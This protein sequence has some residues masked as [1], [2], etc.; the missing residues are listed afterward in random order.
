MVGSDGVTGDCAPR[1]KASDAT[2]AAMRAVAVCALDG[3]A[4]ACAHRSALPSR[5]DR[6][7]HRWSR[8]ATLSGTSPAGKLPVATAPV[9]SGEEK[10]SFASTAK[11]KL[12]ALN[13]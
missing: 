5:F 3:S 9:T 6:A 12:P 11:L 1:L 8:R 13:A 7:A 2:L 10:N 4:S